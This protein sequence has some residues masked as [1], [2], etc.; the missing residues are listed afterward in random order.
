MYAI[1]FHQKSKQKFA[2]KTP[3]WFIYIL[4]LI[5]EMYEKFR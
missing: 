5:F 1:D 4:D 3:C 2:L